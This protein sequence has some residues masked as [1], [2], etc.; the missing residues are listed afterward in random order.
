MHWTC[1]QQSRIGIGWNLS[2]FKYFKLDVISII[3][4]L[5]EIW[6]H[7]YTSSYSRFG[8]PS[9]TK[10]RLS[11][12]NV[13][14]W[15]SRCFNWGMSLPIIL[16]SIFWVFQLG[17]VFLYASGARVVR[18]EEFIQECTFRF[19]ISIFWQFMPTIVRDLWD[20]P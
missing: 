9:Q 11:T 13:E 7:P 10:T 15:S 14:Y 16:A 17:Y 8:H 20:I 5:W 6:I 18:A 4:L 3:A 12:S 1:H 19:R 2:S